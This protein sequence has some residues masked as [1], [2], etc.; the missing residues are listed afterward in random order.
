[1]FNESTPDTEILRSEK[2]LTTNHTPEQPIGREA[3]MARIADAVRPLTRRQPPENLLIYGPAGVG[4]TTFVH[5]VLDNL[6]TETRVTTARIN[7]W[8]YNT[9]SALLTELLIQ[10]GYPAPRKGRPVDTLLATLR[11][12]L[13]KHRGVAVVLDEFD[14][15]HHQ[16]EIVYD[17][18]QTAEDADSPLGLLLVS[19][20]SPASLQLAPR[21]QSRL[22]YQTLEF[23]PYT[24][25]ELVDILKQ[26]AESAFQRGT[27]AAEAVKLIAATV[28]D[29]GGDCRHALDLL[30]RAGRQ[31]EH[32]QAAELTAAHVKQLLR[33]GV[34]RDQ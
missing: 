2:H 9:R 33:S 1:M 10:L 16:T 3:E 5:H 28:A 20:Q 14:R 23:P 30:C 6:A 26:R 21:S 24:D 8:Q 18:Y 29:H 12:W 4:K 31:A 13:D 32:E 7:C 17:L 11:E 25:A 22:T 34:G 27:V 15:L 19:N